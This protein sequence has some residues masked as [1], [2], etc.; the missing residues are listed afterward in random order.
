M[1]IHSVYRTVAYIHY[2]LFILGILF[3]VSL[4]SSSYRVSLALFLIFSYSI[5]SR[6]RDPWKLFCKC[7]LFNSFITK[8]FPVENGNIMNTPDVMLVA[9]YFL[10]Y[11]WA[12]S[13]PQQ[14][15]SQILS[16]S[17]GFV[18]FFC[19]EEGEGGDGQIQTSQEQCGS[20]T[21]KVSQF[22]TQF[23]ILW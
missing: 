15:S 8:G 4:I 20:R 18:T 14:R 11:S 13:Y 7:E 2:Y 22:S 17:K 12:K 19:Q 1:F 23:G 3:L 16:H 6:H 21:T 5:R 10:A 9:W